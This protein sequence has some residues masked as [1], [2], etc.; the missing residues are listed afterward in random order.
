MKKFEI[1][2]SEKQFELIM[3]AFAKTQDHIAELIRDLLRQVYQPLG[4]W[5]KIQNPDNNCE[6]GEGVIGI[7]PH[8]EGEDEWSILNRFDTNSNVRKKMREL[9]KMENPDADVLDDRKFA[10]WLEINKEKLFNGEYT[11][12]L[13]S[14]NRKT[15]DKGNENE[16]FVI[17]IL[18]NYFGGNAK[19][20]RFCSGDVR[21]TKK[22][23]DISVEIGKKKYFIQVK[24]FI[25]IDSYIDA[26][27]G[28]TFFQITAFFEPKKYSEKNVDIFFFVKD[29]EYIAFQNERRK[30]QQP[31]ANKTNFYEPYLITNID[32]SKEP[33]AKRFI[34]ST[35]DK[36]DEVKQLFKTSQ[37]KIDNLVYKKKALED[38][39]NA[40]MEKLKNL[41]GNL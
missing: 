7:Y 32:F 24:P 1:L 2:V 38:L 41:E 22:G 19:V 35:K 33:K 20:K 15:V 36:Q 39:I 5:G 8:L 21:D 12:D 30:I 17:E 40:E 16:K 9:Y 26:S 34:K 25:S 3:E 28:D 29:R 11:E 6:T 13:V 37:R 14:I 23:M 27:E 18:E 10:K 4:K 31:Y